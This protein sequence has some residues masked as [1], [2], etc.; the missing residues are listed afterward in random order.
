MLVAL[1]MSHYVHHFTNQP[2]IQIRI[3]VSENGWTDG[4]L[5]LD[6]L[7]KDFDPQMKDKAAGK[8]RVL[9]MDGHSSHYTADLLEYCIANG[10]EVLGYPHHCTHAL[11]GLDVVCFAR[12]KDIWKEEINNFEGLHLRGVDKEDFCEVFGKAYLHA[13]TPETIKAAF[14]ATGIHPFNPEIITP[15]QMQPSQPTSTKAGFPLPQAS[16]VRAVMAAFGGYAFTHQSLRPD[17]S[18]TT[19]PGPSGHPS[20]H[21][22]HGMA[23][24]PQ[25]INPSLLHSP[26][27]PK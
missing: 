9:I 10:I 15:A 26:H 21:I 22:N 7:K 19:T 18:P 13:F 20:I 5:A 16:P 6:W 11:Q 17:S 8:T 25:P 12:M 24:P 27:T 1:R 14:A 2:K 4:K 23:H 3:C